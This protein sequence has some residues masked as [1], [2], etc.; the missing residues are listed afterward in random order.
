MSF[1]HIF[2]SVD[3]QESAY[4]AMSLSLPTLTCLG[5]S[6][7]IGKRTKIKLERAWGIYE[8]KL[9]NV[10]T[11]PQPRVTARVAAAA[12]LVYPN[13]GVPRLLP[14]ACCRRR[15]EAEARV[16]KINSR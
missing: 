9:H 10:L 11:C 13:R 1:G 7:S 5:S 6:L 3:G 4:L 14:L 12:R 15:P 8:Q 2:V 16:E